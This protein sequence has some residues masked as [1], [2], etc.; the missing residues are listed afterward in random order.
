MKKNKGKEEELGVVESVCF[1]VCLYACVFGATSDNLSPYFTTQCIFQ[2]EEKLVETM[3]FSILLTPQLQCVCFY[4]QV[5]SS[6]IHSTDK[7]INALIKL[8]WRI[9]TQNQ[10]PVR[11]LIK[12]KNLTG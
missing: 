9:H 1:R 2:Q 12:A 6:H 3:S 8:Q 11:H 5:F 10:C 7:N 4:L